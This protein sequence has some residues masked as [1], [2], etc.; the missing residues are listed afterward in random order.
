VGD[1]THAVGAITH[2]SGARTF[3]AKRCR[4]SEIRPQDSEIIRTGRHDSRRG[5]LRQRLI[6]D[7]AAAG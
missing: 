5:S 1:V 2:G 3:G 4:G 7:I 6:D